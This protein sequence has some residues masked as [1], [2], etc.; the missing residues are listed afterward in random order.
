MAYLLVGLGGLIVGAIAA[1]LFFGRRAPVE[2]VAARVS[3]LETTAVDG[4]DGA[5]DN[6]GHG[7]E[8][9]NQTLAQPSRGRAGA[10]SPPEN[11]AA[12]GA[13]HGPGRGAGGSGAAGTGTRVPH[14]A[15]RHIDTTLGL[16]SDLELAPHLASYVVA[17]TDDVSAG[18]YREWPLD[19]YLLLEF[20]RRIAGDLVPA[21][22]GCW[23]TRQ[24]VVGGHE[25]PPFHE[26][27]QHLRNYFADIEARM[28]AWSGEPD[29]RLLEMLA[30]AEWRLLW[31]HPFDDFNGRLTRVFLAEVLRRLHL[32]AVDLAP[33]GEEGARRYFNALH[34][35]DRLDLSALLALWRERLEQGGRSE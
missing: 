16:I 11:S 6:A 17:L 28:A 25:P 31:I 27:P 1:W 23:R 29:D 19:E 4:R 12:G 7:L 35:A 2:Q 9:S 3:D 13:E 8:R 26:I 30:F 24:V 18:G 14:S 15:T 20:H 10:D 33:E 34:A 22:A 5:A 32:P 21:M